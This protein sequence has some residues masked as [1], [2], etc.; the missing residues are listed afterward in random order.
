MRLCAGFYRGSEKEFLNVNMLC[1]LG[2]AGVVLSSRSAGCPIFLWGIGL[3]SKGR[4]PVLVLQLCRGN[5]N[6]NVL[7]NMLNPCRS[8]PATAC[9]SLQVPGQGASKVYAAAHHPE[10]ARNA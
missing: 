10:H 6:L 1:R 2:G 4:L 7:P 3:C 9:G 5:I 8:A